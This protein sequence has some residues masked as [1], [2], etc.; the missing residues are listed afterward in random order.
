MT[1]NNQFH[2][3]KSYYIKPPMTTNQLVEKLFFRGLKFDKK[4]LYDFLEKYNYYKLTGYLYHFREENNESSDLRYRKYDEFKPGTTFKLI[5]E[6]IDFDTELQ[7]FTLKWINVIETKLL[8]GEFINDFSNYTGAFG[9]INKD[10]YR[11]IEKNEK[12]EFDSLIKKL[13]NSNKKNN[14]KG[15]ERYRKKY[16]DKYM[17]IWMISENLTFTTKSLMYKY[18]HVKIRTNLALKYNLDPETMT[19]WLHTLSMIRNYCAHFNRL[20]GR[21]LRISAKKPLK[22]D[23]SFYSKSQIDLYERKKIIL[24]LIRN[25]EYVDDNEKEIVIKLFPFM[26]SITSNILVDN[27][28][29]LKYKDYKNKINKY[30]AKDT[31]VNNRY[32]VAFLILKYF[33]DFFNKG[34]EFYNEFLM[35]IENYPNVNL[36]PLGFWDD[37]RT[38]PILEENN[39]IDSFN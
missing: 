2:D 35:L 20:W 3:I 18:S 8:L 22:I 38:T 7:L 27:D 37:W 9:Y 24:K 6:I 26:D 12:H 34:N 19:S 29:N 13:K 5:K 30:F 10:F 23:N 1:K 14:E 39:K 4:E 11:G 32:I 17:P 15:A 21:Q 25:F 31:F 28:D 16:Y 33:L 36:Y